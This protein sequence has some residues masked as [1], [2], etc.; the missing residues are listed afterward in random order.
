LE[1]N[2]RFRKKKE[3]R[4]PAVERQI[5]RRLSERRPTTKI[6]IFAAGFLLI[7]EVKEPIDLFGWPAQAWLYRIV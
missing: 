1:K 6:I 5:A 4:L 7:A 3:A 2:A